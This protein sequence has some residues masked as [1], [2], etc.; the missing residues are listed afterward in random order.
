MPS[1][2]AEIRID[3]LA[4]PQLT[5]L[6]RAALDYGDSLDIDFSEADVLGKASEITGL[7]DFGP[8]DFRERLAVL[9]TAWG[10]DEGLTGIG[11]LSLHNKIPHYRGTIY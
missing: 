9:L 1:T 6:Q 10:N 11:K 2:T 4:A 8:D 7:D 5:D 3:D